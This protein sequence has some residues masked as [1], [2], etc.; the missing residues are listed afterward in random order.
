M[1]IAA[2]S[3]TVSIAP[4]ESLTTNFGGTS[5]AA[6]VVSG[7]AGW[8]LSVD[9]NLS[10]DEV[11]DLIVQ[12]AEQSPLIT[13]D[14]TGHHEKYGYGVVSPVNIHATFYPSDTDEPGKAGC[15]TLANT[16]SS[17]MFSHL[18]LL[19]AGL[20]FETAMILL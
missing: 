13:P 14:E 20:L 4:N 3:A 19:L 12:T 9:P 16:P 11:V 2:P 10:S 17:V 1:D 7:L 8:I 6:P 5:A 15:N 18:F